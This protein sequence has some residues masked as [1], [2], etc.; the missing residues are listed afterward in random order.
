[1]RYP[2][3]SAYLFSLWL[4]DHRA[5]TRG[6]RKFLLLRPL[7]GGDGGSQ[8]EGPGRDESLILSKQLKNSWFTK[9]EK[10]PYENIDE[11]PESVRHNLPKLAQEIYR[12]AYNSAW[13]QYEN[14]KDRRGD[15]SREEIAHKVAWSAVKDQ[16]EKNEDSN[17]WMPKDR[18]E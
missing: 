8:F 11:L 12:A 17:K 6:K 13:V 14:P 15:A 4:Q 3:V 1:M 7:C 18:D 16:Y 2:R 9:E 10:M 5:W